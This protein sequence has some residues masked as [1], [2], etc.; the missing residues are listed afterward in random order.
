MHTKK[1]S[2]TKKSQFQENASRWK[3]KSAEAEVEV[4]LLIS[5]AHT[6]KEK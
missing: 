2:L 3:P 6:K 5:E 1:V 4:S